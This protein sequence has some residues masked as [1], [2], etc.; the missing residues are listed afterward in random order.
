MRILFI[1]HQFYP[2]FSGGTERVTLNLA[3]AA[4]RAGHYVHVMA[5]TI[6][7]NKCGGFACAELEG[8]FK[9]VY[10]GLPVTFLPRSL[11]PGA[12]GYNSFETDPGLVE[13]L[14][15][16]LTRERFDLAHVMHP[17]RMGSVLLAAQRC[18]LPYLLTLTDFFFVCFLINLINLD[19]QACAG[20]LAGARCADDCLLAPWTHESLARRYQQAQGVLAA[21]GACICPSEYVARRYREE[22]PGQEFKVIPHGID[23]LS[24]RSEGVP[25]KPNRVGDGLTLGFVG[26]IVQQKGLDILLQA[27]SLVQDAS[28]R[29]LIVGGMHG[30]AY[31][32]DVVRRLAQADKRVELLGRLA[33]DQ[34]FRVIQKLDVLCLP[35]R[36]P[37]TFSLVLHEAAAVGV[38]ALVSA[39]GA[40]G[41]QISKHGGGQSLPP[42]DVQAW[43]AA[44][45][46]L[47][48][49]PQ[50]LE[51]WRRELAL[52]LR[53]EE[54]AFFYES[55]YRQLCRS[56][57]V[58]V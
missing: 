53:V 3:R 32:M 8:A 18:G 40:P 51:D 7:P 37:E 43:S 39:L 5:S 30:D 17:M 20:A 50:K 57:T 34:A 23:L 49:N 56:H 4:Q 24:M 52:P 21:A 19:N 42:N 10:Q 9:A 44:I 2:E 28:L 1:L 48:E 54:E 47:A 35:S 15:V 6:D 22:F 38:P 16:W 41:E 13:R 46:N 33:P 58:P 26:S 12:A 31:Y 45:A 11:L 29:L 14:A 27:F 25:V 36:V 55:L